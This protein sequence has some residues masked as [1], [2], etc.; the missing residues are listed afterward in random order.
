[1]QL[2]PTSVCPFV[3]HDLP[4]I[5]FNFVPISV[6][7]YELSRLYQ[8]FADEKVPGGYPKW[9]FYAMTNFAILHFMVNLAQNVWDGRSVT[10]GLTKHHESFDKVVDRGVWS[11]QIQKTLSNVRTGL[12]FVWEI[13]IFLLLVFKLRTLTKSTTTANLKVLVIGIQRNME[14]IV[15]LTIISIMMLALEKIEDITGDSVSAHSDWESHINLTLHLL[16]N[17]TMSC[18]VYL[19]QPHN[20][21]EYGQFLNRIIC[22]KLHFC[23]CCYRGVVVNQRDHFLRERPLIVPTE[24]RAE[25]DT[26]F[27]QFSMDNA[28]SNTYRAP[29][30]FVPSITAS[31]HPMPH[32]VVEQGQ[33][34]LRTP[35]IAGI[36]AIAA[37]ESDDSISG[38]S[39][40]LQEIGI[41]VPVNDFLFEVESKADDEFVREFAFGVYLEYWRS[42]RRNSVI[43]RYMTLKEELLRNRYAA[44]TE[45]EYDKLK[46]DCAKLTRNI[47]IAADIGIMNKIC[48][49]EPDDV[50]T[51]DHVICIKLYTN[52]DHLQLIF[53]K[54]C[55]RLHRGESMESVIR[56]NREIAHWCRHLKE[57]IMFWGERMSAK[58]TVYCGLNAPLIF[59]SLHQRFECPL[60][61]TKE[62]TVADQ[63][64]KNETGHHGV[65]LKLRRANPKTRYLNVAQFT[66]YKNEKERFFMGSTLKIVDIIYQHVSLRKFISALMLFEHILRG[67]FLQSTKKTRKLLLRMLRR[68]IQQFGKDNDAILIDVESADRTKIKGSVT[69]GLFVDIPKYIELLFL[70]FL[71]EMM[72]LHQR[73]SLWLN[74]RELE[75]KQYL[76]IKEALHGDGKLFDL[77]GINKEDIPSVRP[78]QWTIEGY[79]YQELRNLVVSEYAFSPSFVY[80]LSSDDLISIRLRCYGQYIE[81]SPKCAIFIEIEDFPESVEKLRIEA[82]IKCTLYRGGVHGKKKKSM[83]HKQLLKTQILSRSSSV[84]GFQLF[85]HEE[86]IDNESLEWMVGVKILRADHFVYDEH[87]EYLKD[88]YQI[89][90]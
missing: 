57:G 9:L 33:E 56:R 62:I 79:E 2:T 82:D 58:E 40:N 44:I 32:I 8:C 81:D 37:F 34:A 89:L 70:R 86:L 15:I 12:Y 35:S 55:R 7:L 80:P 71:K 83:E 43:P 17:T 78:Y 14:R 45:E 63:F 13:S 68:V 39:E 54:H 28:P 29:I 19:M 38:E 49:I 18:V 31:D 21:R 65:I 52:S 4:D 23:C 75:K 27:N 51:L 30:V 10:C 59:N 60:S 77:W 26:A 88:L 69:D 87:E 36:P 48:G 3:T 41:R 42:N 72:V 5:I 1:M 16:S 53:K 85:D 61:T 90:A 24:I 50:M 11:I 64:S 67:Q 6:G 22:L 76:Q 73:G 84:C 66:Q 25:T 46:E 74:H 20:S 47:F